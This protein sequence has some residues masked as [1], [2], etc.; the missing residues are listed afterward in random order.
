MVE[1]LQTDYF[2]TVEGASEMTIEKEAREFC[3]AIHDERGRQLSGPTCM[4]KRIAE[5]L[6]TK[7][8]R[9]GVLESALKRLASLEA[10][11]SPRMIDK[12]LDC[13]LVARIDFAKKAIGGGK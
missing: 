9:I 5:A 13:E 12:A 3:L 10:F 1:N 8:D 11:T 7:Q 6:Q 2:R 4:C